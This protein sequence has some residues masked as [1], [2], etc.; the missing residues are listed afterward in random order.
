MSSTLFGRI[1][2]AGVSADGNKIDVVVQFEQC[3]TCCSDVI[4][5]FAELL[6]F[7]ESGAKKDFPVELGNSK[8][9]VSEKIKMATQRLAKFRPTVANALEK[10]SLL[11]LDEVEQGH[12]TFII[13]KD[14][15]KNG[16]EIR[17]SHLEFIPGPLSNDSSIG[18]IPP[19]YE[20]RHIAQRQILFWH[21]DD[22]ATS[23]MVQIAQQ[24]WTA[25]SLDK[26]SKAGILLYLGLLSVTG[27]SGN[28]SDDP[29]SPSM[30]QFNRILASSKLDDK[31][32]TESDFSKLLSDLNLTFE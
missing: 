11:I 1:G 28:Q 22:D 17:R 30:R 23:A 10:E 5:K 20:I 32:F 29:S 8:L 12:F 24:L 15:N 13:T 18:S 14:K 16:I 19:Q 31:N 2:H 4:I 7:Y 3:Q 9:T 21:D 25:P 27:T 6:D 26:D